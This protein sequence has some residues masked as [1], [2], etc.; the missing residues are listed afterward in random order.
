MSRT[1]RTGG[2]AEVLRS[3]PYRRLLSVRL[4]SQLGD[5]AFQA[6]LASF[7]LFN[8]TEAPTAPLVAGALSVAVLPFTVVGPFAGV[9]LDRW[10]RQRVLLVSN[11][12]RVVL[13]TL[14]AGVV[15][16]GGG[17]FTGGVLVALYVLVL[18]TLTVNRFLLAGL[19]A[20]LPK[21]VPARLLVPANSITPTL[22]TGAF[23]TGF[24]LGLLVR[25]LVGAAPSTDAA[26]L[27]LAGGLFLTAALL[28]LRIDRRALGP[29]ERTAAS[30]TEAVAAVL[31]G[32][33]EGAVHVWHRP[34]ARN[35]IAVV[36][37][38]RFAFGLSTIATFLLARGYL[39]DDV[40]VGLGILGLAGGA[41]AAG[42]LLA[43]AA[44][45]TATRWL[46][47]LP[48]RR[49][50]GLGGLD[51]WVAAALLVAAGVEALYTLGV[52][53]WSLTAGALVLG[54]CGQVVKIAADTHVQTGVLESV[55]GRAFAFYDVVFNAAFIL[56]AALGALV[57]PDDGYSRLLYGAIAAL[58]LVTGLSYVRVTRRAGPV[59]REG[60]PGRVAQ[61]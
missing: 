48:G 37:A 5:G 19:G 18:A 51:A 49:R 26:V 9:L 43:A 20:A 7:V 39:S 35:A 10:S 24:G 21:T 2:F 6:G 53:V 46:G 42:A 30:S 38:H 40:D 31:R 1:S 58:Y 11:L 17:A 4:A 56:A 12:V 13:V 54:L 60:R 28:A 50:F 3:S 23:G 8:P 59:A 52:A 47:A 41:A 14:V 27:L 16:A 25:L 34:A 55:R 32:L 22:G 44:T 57:I 33:R 45:P 61:E 29:D 36:G 15:L